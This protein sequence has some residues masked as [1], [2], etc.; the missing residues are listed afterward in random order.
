MKLH[1][2]GKKEAKHKRKMGHVNL[3]TNDVESGAAWVEDT[4]IWSREM[5]KI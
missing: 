1:L 3:F 5:S 4:Q 2:Y